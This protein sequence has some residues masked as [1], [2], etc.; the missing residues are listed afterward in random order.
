VVFRPEP[1]YHT[2]EDYSIGSWPEAQRQE[3]IE[4]WDREHPKP[5]P[6]ADKVETGEE[7]YT[8]PAG[9]SDLVDHLANFFQ[10]VRTRKPV[11]ENETFGNVAA[12]TGCHMSNFSYFNRTVAVWDESSK[13][14]ISEK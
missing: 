8:A 11:V 5:G 14:L 4:Q 13:K 1:P 7:V 2:R 9:Y 10:A 6:G 3:Y 12:L